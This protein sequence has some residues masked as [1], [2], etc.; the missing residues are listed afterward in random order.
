MSTSRRIRLAALWTLAVALA[1]CES[2]TEPQVEPEFDAEAALADYA[3]IETAL[4]SSEW[5]G[6]KALGARS[7]FG[8][9]PAAIDVV[10]GLSAPRAPGGGRAFAID[11]AERLTDAWAGA[12]GNGPE[13]API[14]SALIRGTT[15]VYD[16]STDGYVPDPA[17]EGAPEAGVR[18]IMYAL[19]EAGVPKVDEEIGYAD[20]IDE[21]DQ[22]AEDIVLRLT[23][24]VTGTTILDYRTTLDQQGDRGA[25]TVRGFL[26]GD[27]VRLDFDLE[28]AALRAGNQTTLD[29]AFE[30]RVDA[31]DFSIVG[32][33]KGIDEGTEGEGDIDVTVRHRNESIRVDVRGRDG[34]IEGSV[35]VNGAVF[36]TVRGPVDDPT[37]VGA[38]GAP[39][40][41]REFLVLR[42][43]FDT[44]EDIF[45][46]LEDLV[47]PVDDL[48]ILGIVL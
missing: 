32:S 11:L 35:F 44:V 29:V 18:F 1:A 16:P 15:F 40:K 6:F 26:F 5:A 34:M 12:T 23:V 10:V 22:S 13:A 39:L 24:V 27:D 14:I 28:L 42:Q 48:V 19:D 37:I 8:G 3:A 21:G 47:D 36:A 33:V 2:G 25:L 38:S 43:I 30:L 9:T 7:P 31:R 20:L 46:F 41:W 4:G 45:D 17:R